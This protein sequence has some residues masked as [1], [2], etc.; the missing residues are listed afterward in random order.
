MA[1]VPIFPEQAKYQDLYVK[2]L[3]S[4]I[5]GNKFALKKNWKGKIEQL[6]LPGLACKTNLLSRYEA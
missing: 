1:D 5:V 2:P 4:V 3:F 6:R